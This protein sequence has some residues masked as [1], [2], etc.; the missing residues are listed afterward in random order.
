[1][2]RAF[3]VGLGELLFGMTLGAEAPGLVLSLDEAVAQAL[4][5][6]PDL[7]ALA[8]QANSALGQYRWGLREYLPQVG[9]NYSQNESVLLDSPDTRS[10]QAGV[11]V[12]QLLFDAGRGGRRRDLSRIQLLVNRQDSRVQEEK[13]IDSVTG[14]FNE[15]LVLKKKREIQAQ[16]IDLAQ[17]QLAI[18]RTELTLGL[19]REIDVLGTEVQV[20]SLLVDKKQSDR[21]WEDALF[22]LANLL[23]LDP[24]VPLDVVGSFDADY[25]G[26]VVP[27]HSDRWL[28]LVLDSSKDLALQRLELRKQYFELLNSR[29]W[30]LPDV[31]LQTSVSL[32][33]VSLPLQTPAYSATLTFSF[34]GEAFPFTQTLVIGGTPGQSQTSSVSSSVGILD[35]VQGFADG[36]AAQAQFQVT[37]V[38]EAALRASTRF[39]LEKT[40]G[41]YRLVVEKLAL[42]RR[43]VGLEEQKNL[44]LGK[45]VELGEAKR[46]DYLQGVAQL[47]QDRIALIESVLQLKESERALEQ[48]LHRTPGTLAQAVEEEGQ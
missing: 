14:L 3:L 1:M 2:S 41:D 13:V 6:S 8:I 43:T 10:T 45:Q 28:A 34:P 12:S 40:L 37:Q 32:T 19:A 44:I 4:E 35:S 30:F 11:T 22:Q 29:L 7:Q 36:P 18:S 33:G 5:V 17:R 39:T 9:L 31:S 42:Q 21:S 23:G 38:R 16:V 25:A 20:S 15:L 24:T 48:L 26:L 47:A 46:L 27:E